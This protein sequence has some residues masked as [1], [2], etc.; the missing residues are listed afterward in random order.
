MVATTYIVC[1]AK[2]T[3]CVCDRM[4]NTFCTDHHVPTTTNLPTIRNIL[5]LSRPA[6]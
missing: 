3:L 2:I 1:Y 6:N 5:I 4:T